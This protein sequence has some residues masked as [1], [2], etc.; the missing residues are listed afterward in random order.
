MERSLCRPTLFTR[1]TPSSSAR[2][3]DFRAKSITKPF[4]LSVTIRAQQNTEGVATQVNRR[5]LLCTPPL[6]FG[7]SQLVFNPIAPAH[8]GVTS[9]YDLTVSQYDQPFALDA[10]RGKVT[11]VLNV[12]SE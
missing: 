4:R 2:K 11:V 7:V 3:V 8:A 12:A 10:F 9:F 6:A 5:Q 1:Q